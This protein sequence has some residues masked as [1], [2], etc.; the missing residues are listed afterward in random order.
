M[1][2]GRSDAQS[3]ISEYPMQWMGH[4]SQ[5]MRAYTESVCSVEGEDRLGEGFQNSGEF[6]LKQC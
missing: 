4:H 6:G 2:D 3:V 1:V 5:N